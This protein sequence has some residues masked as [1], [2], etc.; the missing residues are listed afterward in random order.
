MPTQT[1]MSKKP[2]YICL[3]QWKSGRSFMLKEVGLT[4][5]TECGAKMMADSEAHELPMGEVLAV[6]PV[7]QMWAQK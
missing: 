6:R 1:T 7:E 5:L 4:A 2:N 3:L